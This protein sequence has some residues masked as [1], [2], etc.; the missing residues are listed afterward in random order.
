MTAATLPKY[1]GWRRPVGSYQDYEKVPDAAGETFAEVYG[2]LM[3]LELLTHEGQF[4]YSIQR[5]G[6]R[7]GRTE[8][9]K[10]ALSNS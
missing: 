4:Q 10:K 3:A 9:R 1:Q 2:K 6:E 7:P 8:R 5:G